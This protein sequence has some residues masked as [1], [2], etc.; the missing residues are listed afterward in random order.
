M[1]LSGPQVSRSLS[2]GHSTKRHKSYV[3]NCMKRLRIPHLLSRCNE[4]NQPQEK[5]QQQR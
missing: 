5:R 4:I 2:W 3:S 1:N